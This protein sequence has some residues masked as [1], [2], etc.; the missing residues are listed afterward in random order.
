M[1]QTGA[2][3]EKYIKVGGKSDPLVIVQESKIWPC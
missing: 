1:Q 3:I 2:K